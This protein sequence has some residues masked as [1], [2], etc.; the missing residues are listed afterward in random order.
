MKIK[1]S[2]KIDSIVWTLVAVGEIVV[3]LV[4]GAASYALWNG[5]Y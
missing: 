1:T 5:C 4:A 2:K 3:P